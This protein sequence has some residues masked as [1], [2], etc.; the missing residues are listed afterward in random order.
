MCVSS[1]VP[2]PG[3]CPWGW[4]HLVWAAPCRRIRTQLKKRKQGD[5]Q[6]KS[7]RGRER[8]PQ[9]EEVIP[10]V[11]RN[12]SGVTM[13]ENSPPHGG[14]NHQNN[15]WKTRLCNLDR[16]VSPAGGI[17]RKAAVWV[18]HCGSWLHTPVWG[19]D[20]ATPQ[21]GETELTAPP[22]LCKKAEN[23]SCLSS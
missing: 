6:G 18:H 21:K 13:A 23:H 10:L 7:K 9:N 2:S 5:S 11:I 20:F 17:F 8:N 14:M 19:M 1:N 22:E 4:E 12:R 15:R 3:P 16:R